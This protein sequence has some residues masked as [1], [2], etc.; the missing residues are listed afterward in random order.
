MSE[1][2]QRSS[3]G[4]SVLDAGESIGI[5]IEEVKR[6]WEEFLAMIEG[7]KASHSST[8]LLADEANALLIKVRGQLEEATAACSQASSTKN[9]AEEGVQRAT[10]L[11]DQMTSTRDQAISLLRDV[12]KDA[13]A[14]A[15]H[16]NTAES[17][18]SRINTLKDTAQDGSSAI[19]AMKAQADLDIVSISVAKES[20]N[21]AVT[22]LKGL[23]DK[24]KTVQRELTDYEGELEGLI[25]ATKTQLETITGL[26][27]GATSAGCSCI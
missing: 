8:G 17:N 11:L 7:A 5:S 10:S 21:E 18:S 13:I 22:Q 20:G 23:A 9:L 6:R 4:K 19:S 3:N 24:A 27:P 25:E 16:T 26:L 2:D 15:K 12:E 1:S 14:A